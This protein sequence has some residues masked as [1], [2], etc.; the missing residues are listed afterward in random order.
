MSSNHLGFEFFDDV[1][2][3]GAANAGDA[4]RNI[5]LQ[6]G[7]SELVRLSDQV[8]FILNKLSDQISCIN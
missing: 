3:G 8:S 5:H 1:R 4:E 2:G 6:C 7:M